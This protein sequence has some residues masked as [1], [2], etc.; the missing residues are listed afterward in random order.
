[1]LVIVFFMFQF[2]KGGLTRPSHYSLLG[3]AKR[4]PLFTGETLPIELV[5]S[6]L[7][8]HFDEFPY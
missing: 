8:G 1:M 5:K 4:D 3:N 7:T 2:F 6:C